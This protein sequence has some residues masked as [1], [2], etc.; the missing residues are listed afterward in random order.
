MPTENCV[1]SSSHFS[2]HLHNKPPGKVLDPLHLSLRDSFFHFLLK[3]QSETIYFLLKW[4][5]W[6]HLQGVKKRWWRKKKSHYE[7]KTKI[8][9]DVSAVAK[10][11]WSEHAY[12]YTHGRG[13][14]PPGD[15]LRTPPLSFTNCG[16]FIHL[17][18]KRLQL[19]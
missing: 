19:I 6:S 17:N 15:R 10:M 16:V 9:Y 12:F 14:L 18:W 5:A 8:V 2:Q 13:D 11:K 7:W 4:F 1:R 3:S